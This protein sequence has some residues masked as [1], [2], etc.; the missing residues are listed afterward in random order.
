MARQT[1]VSGGTEPRPGL[2][3]DPYLIRIRDLVCRAAGIFQP[4][5]KLYNLKT[6]C[7]RRMQAVG[8]G[9][10]R[11]YFN[12]LTA[13]PSHEAELRELLNEIT[14]SETSF[15]RYPPQLDALRNV[16][17]PSIVK[18][19]SK[20]AFSPLR[21][22]SAACSTGEEPY[23]LAMVLT[24]EFPGV[25][26]DCGFEILA[27]DLN[28][29]SLAKAREGIYAPYTLR[30]VPPSLKQKYF[31][32]CGDQFQVADELKAKISFH[33]L[34]LCDDSKIAF[35]KG[36]D[37]IFCCNVLIYFNGTA[38]QRTIQ[39]LYD[40]LLPNGY[41]FLGH[42]ESLFGINDDFQVVHFP[43][44]TAYCKGCK[45]TPAGVQ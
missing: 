30:N 34:N 36:M 3:L 41:L 18:A 35:M 7:R 45:S 24:E 27:T 17:L 8:A 21:I 6:R 20:F 40:N 23:T 33:H 1:V 22:W 13:K 2:P 38:S 31:R 19:K 25:L 28:D 37:V 43:T 16:V 10:L 11:D 39:H 44:A 32:A 15:F 12:Y 14:V 4:D 42:S 29:C 5:N 26:K 9:S